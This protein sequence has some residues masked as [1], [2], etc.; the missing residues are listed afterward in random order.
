MS[1][2]G[3]RATFSGKLGFILAT[4]ASA[5]GLGN[6]WRFPYET[7]H[8]G[9]GIFVLIYVIL[10]FTFGICLMMMEISLGRKT[11]KS[12]IAAFGE[13]S[14]KHKSI[15]YL[16]AI[17]PF[18]I[19]PTYC[20]IGGWV[21]KW[22][23]E[24]TTGNLSVLAKN[25]GD[26]WWQF[27]TGSEVGFGEPSFWFIV[28]GFIC[29]LCIIGGVEKGIEKLSRILMPVLL[30]LIVGIICYEM[31]LPGIWDG[32]V[33]YLR[34]DMSALTPNTFL[35][36]VSQIFYS[37]SI[38]MGVLVTYGSYTKNDVDIEE[39]SISIGA[40]DTLVAVMAGL[41]IIPVAFMFNFS[42]EQGMGLMFVALPQ[43]FAE[44]TGGA[45]L[46]PLFYLLVL[47]AALTSA[48]SMAE[49]CASIFTDGTKMDRGKSIMITASFI[50]ILGMVCV[51]SFGNGPLAVNLPFDQGVGWLGFFD[52]LANS[53]IMPISA[54]V[55]CIFIGYVV[56]ITVLEDDIKQSSP[57]RTRRIFGF[58]IKYVCP[59][60]LTIILIA[61]IIG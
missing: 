2:T 44:M 4:S 46:A 26:Y 18:L 20:V 36:A 17:A 56:K 57:F 47:F 33:Y 59:I 16:A 30:I 9:G 15:G 21:L 19:L 22:L 29:I 48:V 52:S 49:A 14:Q 42:D 10:A 13:L 61:G 34:P 3:E 54:I 25:G 31:T 39:S 5:V 24:T 1:E 55:T 28:F 37:M 53:I 6:L 50:I 38:S 7:S 43:V 8:Y 45:I 12:S 60:L 23:F 58:M 27:V 40:I 51:L 35:G 32:V 11:R 41:M